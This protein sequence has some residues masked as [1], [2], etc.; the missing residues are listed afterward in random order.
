MF[1]RN[2]LV[3]VLSLVITGCS[4]RNEAP[5]SIDTVF[6]PWERPMV[7][8]VGSVGYGPDSSLLLTDWGFW[9][10]SGGRTLFRVA[11]NG[12]ALDMFSGAS[13]CTLYVYGGV[14]GPL[15]DNVFT[16]EFSGSN[17]VT[18]SVIWEGAARAVTLDGAVTLDEAGA[19]TL[20]TTSHEGQS[21]LEVDLA[22]ATV[23]VYITGIGDPMIWQDLRMYAGYFL[24]D[25][26][27]YMRGAFFGEHHEGVAGEFAVNQDLLGVFGALRQ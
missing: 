18:G 27:M 25:E 2:I 13:A 22:N 26:P 16:G 23:D 10:Q 11:M 6:D 15:L 7:E 5:E 4:G 3:V 20:G 19:V 17:P 8:A 9:V 21:R 1:M 24:R 12:P 14:C